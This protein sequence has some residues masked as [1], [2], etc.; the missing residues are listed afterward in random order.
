[1]GSN[2]ADGQSSEFSQ[3]NFA[4]VRDHALYNH[5]YFAGLIFVDNTM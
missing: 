2:F 5:A 4:D 1:M 3:F